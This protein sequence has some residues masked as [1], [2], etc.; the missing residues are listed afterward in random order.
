MA[1]QRALRSP[2]LL[3]IYFDS[4]IITVM[5]SFNEFLEF[6]IYFAAGYACLKFFFA[7]L[8]IKAAVKEAIRLRQE[9]TP[10]T[11]PVRFE[12]IDNV[13]FVWNS[14]NNEFLGQGR[15]YKEVIDNIQF[16]FRTGIKMA[17]DP[18]DT[19]YKQLKLTKER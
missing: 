1:L 9:Q 7:Y 14:K 18:T 2:F 10:I 13:Y 3:T 4:I 16:R 6:I 19:V 8:E 11:V 17:V 15:T 5:Q 12:F